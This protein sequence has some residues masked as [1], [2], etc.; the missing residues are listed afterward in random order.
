MDLSV[1]GD[2]QKAHGVL[3]TEDSCPVVISVAI[4]KCPPNGTP[5]LVLDA[6]MEEELCAS[7][8]VRLAVTP[9]GEVVA[10]QNASGSLPLGLLPEVTAAA[11]QASKHVFAALKTATVTTLH[12]ETLLQPQFLIR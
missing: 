1:D 10:I 2:I 6:T 7:C 9:S 11:V 12:Q 4:C 8:I 3:E 5:V